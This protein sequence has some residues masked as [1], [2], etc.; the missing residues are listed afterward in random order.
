MTSITSTPLQVEAL[1]L[2]F[3]AQVANRLHITQPTF[4][5]DCLSLASVAASR[6]IPDA[7]TPWSIRKTLADFFHYSSDLQSQVF[8]VPREIN[9]IAHNVAHQVLRSDVKPDICCFASAHRN[10]LCPV[11]SLLSNFQFQGFVIPAVRC[12]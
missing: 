7:S 9:G 10:M 12:Y 5:T 1:A 11:V 8:H 6:R 2:L 3:A 4:L